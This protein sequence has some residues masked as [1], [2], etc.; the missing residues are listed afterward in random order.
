MQRLQHVLSAENQ[1][2]LNVKLFTKHLSHLLHCWGS[3]QRKEIGH[4]SSWRMR[5]SAM[6]CYLQ[7]VTDI[8]I[9]VM[10]TQQPWW[11]AQDYTKRDK[12]VGWGLPGNTKKWKESE[13]QE[14]TGRTPGC[15]HT[16]NGQKQFKI[17]YN[18]CKKQAT[19]SYVCRRAKRA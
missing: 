10:T 12:E 4:C 14:A 19:N 17:I 13:V 6:E 16:W 11:S 9:A 7:A 2:Q 3:S 1:R 5:K 15:T 8:D 18:D